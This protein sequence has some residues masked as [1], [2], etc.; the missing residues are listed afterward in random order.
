MSET[1]ETLKD[2]IHKLES[3][4]TRIREELAKREKQ[5]Q[6]RAIKTGVNRAIRKHK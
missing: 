3:R 1:K 4:I 5:L 6:E 2:K